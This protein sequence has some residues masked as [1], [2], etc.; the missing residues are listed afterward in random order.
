MRSN[1]ITLVSHYHALK[2]PDAQELQG[3]QAVIHIILR[4]KGHSQGLPLDWSRG[5]GKK[6]EG[7][8][9]STTRMV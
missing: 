6:A 2:R 9:V 5:F 4:R 8:R 3:M 1:H 7:M